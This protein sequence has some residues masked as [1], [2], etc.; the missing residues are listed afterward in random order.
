MIFGSCVSKYSRAN[1][2]HPSFCLF[3]SNLLH[4]ISSCLR[5]RLARRPAHFFQKSVKGL[6]SFPI[7]CG[8]LIYARWTS[9]CLV[10]RNSYG[11]GVI[12]FGNCPSFLARFF[13][14]RREE[15]FY[16]CFY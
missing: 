6:S 15:F 7:L 14:F 1:L 12:L 13:S 10:L 11:R 9:L 8:D 4:R 3:A 5:K 16:C 2:I